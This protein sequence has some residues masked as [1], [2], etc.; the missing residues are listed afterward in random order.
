MANSALLSLLG[1]KPDDTQEKGYW[2]IPS[3]NDTQDVQGVGS[4][5]NRLQTILKEQTNSL[6]LKQKIGR[7]SCRERV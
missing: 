4:A 5:F 3:G 2:D 7:A 6:K 1:I